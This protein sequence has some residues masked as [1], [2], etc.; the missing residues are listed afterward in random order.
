MGSAEFYCP[1]GDLKW[2]SLKRCIRY[3]WSWNQPKLLPFSKILVFIF[4][5]LYF[6]KTALISQETYVVSALMKRGTPEVAWWGKGVLPGRW[7]WWME[8]GCT[9]S[10][11]CEYDAYRDIVVSACGRR[12]PC[13]T[14]K[15]AKKAAYPFKVL[16]TYHGQPEGC[17]RWWSG[18]KAQGRE[19]RRWEEA[20]WWR[21]W[22]R[23]RPYGLEGWW[24]AR[25]MM[26]K[27]IEVTINSVW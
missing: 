2:V 21:I 11:R 15:I 16:H 22:I 8:G 10:E 24:D 4:H 17:N 27:F 13:S 6:S 9:A 12:G 26:L 25:D 23:S 7:Y 1:I 19:G 5:E 18:F 20:R 3:F 14:M